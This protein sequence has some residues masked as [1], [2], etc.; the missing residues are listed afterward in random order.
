MMLINSDN[1]LKY[2]RAL[3]VNKAFMASDHNDMQWTLTTQPY[4][5]ISLDERIRHCKFRPS[6]LNNPKALADIYQQIFQIININNK[7]V[8]GEINKRLL[9]ELDLDLNY[10][11]VDSLLNHVELLEDI[12]HAIKAIQVDVDF[13]NVK[14]GI[15][16][17]FLLIR[18]LNTYT[19]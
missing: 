16:R 19:H 3:L 2:T 4:K 13:I 1:P 6:L 15:V 5:S 7:P 9:G 14:K 11:P 8:I 18:N 12:I 10:D 17:L